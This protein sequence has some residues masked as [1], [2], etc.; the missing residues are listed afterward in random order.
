MTFADAYGD[1]ITF[2]TSP[3]ASVKW[4]GQRT[5]PELDCE[6]FGI[7]GEITTEGVARYIQDLDEGLVDAQV[8]ILAWGVNDLRG[9]VWNA[10][11][12]TIGPLETAAIA[13]VAAGKTPVFWIPTPQFGPDMQPN[14][15][16]N[17][18][19]LN[20]IAPALHDL[21][22]ELNAPIVDAYS[23]ML[24]GRAQP[25]P[26]L[27]A[28]HVHPNAAGFD[29]LAMEAALSVSEPSLI[30]MTAVGICAV[31]VIHRIRGNR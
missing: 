26:E 22:Q 12:D 21:A 15:L 4:C 7:P 28:D 8:V 31:V 6:P 14:T 3:D 20:T 10:E 2:D 27:Y 24:D 17:G 5:R 25:N 1:S 30:M 13:T 16:A 23:A 18:R 29:A 19:V 9:P 11:A